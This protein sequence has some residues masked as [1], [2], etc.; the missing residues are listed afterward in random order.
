MEKLAENLIQN[1]YA[2][3]REE[4]GF[5]KEKAGDTIQ[6]AIKNVNGCI[7]HEALFDVKT[8]CALISVQLEL[9]DKVS[10]PKKA[11]DIS[12]EKEAKKWAYIIE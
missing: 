5:I 4:I 11:R 3:I 1:V 6:E 2:N 9:L 7:D 12:F 10:I 8:E